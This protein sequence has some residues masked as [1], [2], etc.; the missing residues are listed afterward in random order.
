MRTPRLRTLLQASGV[1]FAG[2]AFLGLA[3]GTLT[4]ADTV[5]GSTGDPE[6]PARALFAQSVG[7]SGPIAQAQE[8]E[9][10]PS[11]DSEQGDSVEDD[12]RLVISMIVTDGEEPPPPPEPTGPPSVAGLRFWTGGDSTAT[13]MSIQLVDIFDDLGAAASDTYYQHSTG[14][15]RPDYFDWIGELQ[16][17]VNTF[18]P[19]IVVFMV[20]AND[21]Q[22]IR[23]DE[24]TAHALFSDGWIAEYS[25]RVGEVMDLLRSDG[26]YVVYVGQ[27]NMGDP[28]FAQK[29]A[30][31]NAIIEDEASERPAVGYLDAWTLFSDA[32]GA[33]QAILPDADGVPTLYRYSDGIHFTTAG[34]RRLA[35]A[36]VE[37][38]YRQL[39]ARPPLHLLLAQELSLL[40]P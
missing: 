39:R 33:Y 30:T 34:G 38:V 14:L 16:G 32:N 12:V 36:V 35:D 28:G 40:L 11:D 20:G 2:L 13:Y 4:T 15:S 24:G 37:E 23:D 21:A 25:R 9:T 10:E 17:V 19:D 18:K 3:A 7:D 31:I 26:R 27:A 1:A 5:E 8:Q 29:M 22:P 6:Q